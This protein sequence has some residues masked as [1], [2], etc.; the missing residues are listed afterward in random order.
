[1]AAKTLMEQVVAGRK[2]AQAPPGGGYRR[3]LGGRAWVMDKAKGKRVMLQARVP[4]KAELPAALRDKAMKHD[5]KGDWVR[6]TTDDLAVAKA[7][8]GWAE[9]HVVPV[10]ALKAP[11]KTPAP[12]KRK[13]RS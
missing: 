7:F 12:R 3:V 9:E 11:G 4:E 2:D 10:A 13:A 1:M 8:V 6:L 5:R